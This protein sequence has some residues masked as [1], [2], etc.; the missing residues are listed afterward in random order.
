M[1]LMFFKLQHYA[2]FAINKKKYQFFLKENNLFVFLRKV[3]AINLFR[4][5][6]GQSPGDTYRKDHQEA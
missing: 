2:I 4:E 3:E 6:L 1:I 5:H